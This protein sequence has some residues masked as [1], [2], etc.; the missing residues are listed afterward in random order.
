MSPRARSAKTIEEFFKILERD[1]AR[2]EKKRR[3]AERARMRLRY[4]ATLE[5]GRANVSL[6]AV[7]PEHPFYNLSG[8]DNIVAFTTKHYSK[9][10]LVVKGPGAG[11]KVTAAGV[12]ADM[13]RTARDLA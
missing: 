4:I 10:P 2:F 12:F 9:T 6:R 7:S 3:A 1:D 11:A 5:K 13:L 8:S